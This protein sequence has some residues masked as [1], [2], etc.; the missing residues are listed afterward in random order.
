MKVAKVTNRYAIYDD[1]FSRL[2]HDNYLIV[3]WLHME[4]IAACKES[5]TVLPLIGKVI[6]AASNGKVADVIEPLLAKFGM[7]IDINSIDR[8][9]DNFIC[10]SFS[11]NEKEK[12]DEFWNSIDTSQLFAEFWENGKHA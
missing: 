2:S 1:Y 12:A 5:T 11:A 7:E 3:L 6:T 4:D 10:I 9:D 8:D